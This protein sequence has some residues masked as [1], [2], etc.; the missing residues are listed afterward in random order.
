[1]WRN[2]TDGDLPLP[3]RLRLI[4]GNSWWKVRSRQGCCGHYG[5]PG[6]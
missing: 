3:R 5:E 4:V 1:M 2:L 6:C